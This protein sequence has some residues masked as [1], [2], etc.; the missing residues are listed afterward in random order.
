MANVLRAFLVRIKGKSIT[1]GLI[2]LKKSVSS[3]EETKDHLFENAGFIDDL[4]KEDFVNVNPRRDIYNVTFTF[5][6]EEKKAIGD[7][8]KHNG[9]KELVQMILGEVKKCQSAEAK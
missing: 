1:K 8:I 9:K 7:Y 5:P 3:K 2:T 6:R 4:L